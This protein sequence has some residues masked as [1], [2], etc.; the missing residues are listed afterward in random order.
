MHDRRRRRY[1]TIRRVKPA[2]SL[3]GRCSSRP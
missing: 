3:P 2:R 1:E